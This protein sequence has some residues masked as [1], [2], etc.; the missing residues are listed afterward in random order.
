MKTLDEIIAEIIELRLQIDFYLARI[1]IL[2]DKIV[3]LE[4]KRD[5]INQILYPENSCNLKVNLLL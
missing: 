3:E 1:K 2:N 5:E 4:R